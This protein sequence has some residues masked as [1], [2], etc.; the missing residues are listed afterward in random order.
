MKIYKGAWEENLDVE[1]EKD[2]FVYINSNGSRWYGEE[3]ASID[4][5]VDV[6]KKYTLRA[7]YNGTERNPVSSYD[8][9]PLFKNVGVEMFYGNFEEISHVFCIYTNHKETIDFMRCN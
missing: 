3:P 7:G 6:L 5:L 2:D 1:S 4:E 9:K 8:Y